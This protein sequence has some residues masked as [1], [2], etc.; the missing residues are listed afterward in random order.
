MNLDNTV[1]SSPEHYDDQPPQNQ[2][3]LTLLELAYM[4]GASQQIIEELLEVELIAP[5]VQK[6]EMLFDVELLPR[7]RKIVRLHFHLDVSFSSMALV[8]E[9]LD[10]IDNLEKRLAEMESEESQ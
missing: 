10:R 6:P 4:V 1:M 9:L 5:C 3:V 7:I 2:N 8:L